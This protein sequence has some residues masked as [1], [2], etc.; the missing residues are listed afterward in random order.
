MD[1]TESKT[2]RL[3]KKQR[4]SKEIQ[5][6]TSTIQKNPKNKGGAMPQALI[7]SFD[8]L[9]I[10]GFFWIFEGCF[11]ISLEFLWIFLDF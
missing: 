9:C 6:K 10:F 3:K 2:A 11:G 7:R 1:P 8:P 4:N 5:K